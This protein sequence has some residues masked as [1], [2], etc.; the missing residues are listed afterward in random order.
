MGKVAED[1]PEPTLWQVFL[2]YVI[3]MQSANCMRGTPG[4]AGGALSPGKDASG[5]RDLVV[6]NLPGGIGGPLPTDL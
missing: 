3:L 6:T 4:G 2:R 5:S 1:P